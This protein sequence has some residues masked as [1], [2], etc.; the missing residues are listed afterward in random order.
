MQL[1]KKAKARIQGLC[2][3]YPTTRAALLPALWVA[4]EELGYIS[5]EVALQVADELAIPVNAVHEA[6]SFYVLYHRE[7]VGKNV[8]WLCRNLSCYLCG[9]DDIKAHLESTLGVREGE[10]TDDGMFT[11]RSNECLGACGGAPMMQVN[12]RYYEDLTPERVDEILA[13]L[14]E[15]S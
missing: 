1:S 5:D 8:I 4:Q 9:Y 11:L 3:R 14:R 10:T 13:K 7:P 12:D 2:Q 6:L 15:A